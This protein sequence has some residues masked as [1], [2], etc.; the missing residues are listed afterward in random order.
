[1][2]SR[3]R[4]QD[5]YQLQE[6]LGRGGMG[7]VYKARDTLMNR[8]V[9]LKTIL[10]VE[11]RSALDLFYKEWAVQAS[12]VHPNIVE[13]YDIGEFEENGVVKPFFVM[14]LLPGV[15][16]DQLIR[17]GS[18]TLTVERS[19]G[20][21]GQACRGLQAAHDQGLVHR[22][23][24][25]SN[26]F[27]MEDDSVKIIDFGVA[28]LTGTGAKTTLKGTLSYMAP[29]QL[30]MKAPSALSDIF[31]L[32][33]VCYQT[34]TRRLPFHGNSEYEITE[35]IL[36]HSPAPISE[37]NSS[38]NE[39]I[40]S[41]VHK[42]MAKRPW[43]RFPNAK[44][45]A[46]TLQK[47]LHNQPLAFLDPEKIKP[48]IERATKAF[49]EGD[50]DFASEVLFELEA[51]G[52][53]DPQIT[54]MRRQLDQ[55]VRKST[56][57]QLLESARRFFEAAEYGLALRKTQEAL[58]LDED[59]ADALTLQNQIEKERHA[60][61]IDEWFL[62]A[63]Q[64][65][66]N[67]AFGQARQAIE[68]VLKL[69]PSDTHALQLSAEV[70]R[71]ERETSQ[72][73]EEKKKLYEAA[74]KA[75]QKGEITASLSKLESL[76]S[77]E[78]D[79]P[80][81][82][83]GRGSTYQKFYQQVRSEHDS[84]K[85]AY[86]EARTLVRDNNFSAARTLCDQYL[87]KYP[88]HALFQ[89][90]KVDLE[91][92]Q[93][94]RLSAVIAE[95]DQRVDGEPDLDRRLGILQE[96][97]KLYPEEV[98]FERSARIVR[99]KRD[100]VNSIVAKAR[101]FEE[102][103]QLNEALDQWQIL[104]TIHAR[105]PGLE[106]EIERLTK[107][108]DQQA[109]TEAKARWGEQVDRHLESGDYDRAVETC[110]NALAE[111]PNDDSLLELEKL[112]RRSKERSTEAMK[113]LNEGRELC[114][115]GQTEK[116]LE[117][118]RRAQQLDERSSVPRKVLVN[119]LIVAARQLVD[120]N[121]K[122]AGKLVKEVLELEPG[123][124]SAQSLR[125]QIADHEREEFVN[126]CLAQARRLQTEGDIEAAHATVAKG[127]ASYPNEP[128]LK[129]LLAT[130]E[131]VQSSGGTRLSPASR[132]YEELKRLER[133]MAAGPDAN[134]A[135]QL[136]EQVRAIASRYPEEQAIQSLAA[137]LRNRLAAVIGSPAAPGVS[138]ATPSSALDATQLMGGM[139]PPPR[140]PVPAAPAQPERRGAEAGASAAGASA[141]KPAQGKAAAAKAAP[142]KPAGPSFGAVLQQQWASF[143]G[144]I[145]A[146]G[147][148]RQQLLIVGG[149][150]AGVILVAAL[151]FLIWSSLGNEP[152]PPP[153][154]AIR[155]SLQASPSE[156]AISVGEQQCGAGNCE[157][158]LQP[159]TYQAQARLLGY[160]AA[161]VSFEVVAPPAE[162]KPVVLLLEPLAPVLRLTSDLESG[163]VLL[164][165]APVGKL[166]DG[167]FELAN[168][169]MGEHTLEVTTRGS[170][171]SIRF[172]V[173]AGSIPVIG[174]P[175]QASNLKVAAVGSLGSAA[176]L[177]SE[178]ANAEAL[179]DGQA[180]GPVPA[181]GLDLPNLPEGAHEVKLGQGNEQLTFAFNAGG[182]PT[183]AAFLKSDRNVGG[184]RIETG[185]DAVT[186][187]L[188]GQEYRR[189]TQRGRLL[190]Y[191]MPRQYSV[192][193]EKPGF[194]AVGEQVA[195]VVRGE[196]TRLEFKFTP[197]PETASL[198]I[199]NAPPGAEV[200][201]DGG[202]L[203]TIPAGSNTGT[204][205]LAAGTHTVSLRQES[206]TPKEWQR[207]FKAGESV[208]LDG[209][210]LS[211]NGTL[212]ITVEPA[213]ID[214]L[215]TLRRDREAEE[216][217]I[218]A[219]TLTLP[220]GTY[221]VTARADG[222]QEFAA[223]V[224]VGANGTARA[225]IALV[226]DRVVGARSIS[227]LSALAQSGWEQEGKLLTRRGGEFVLSPQGAET[228]IYQFTVFAQ[229]GRRL[230]WVVNFKDDNNHVLYQ[231][232]RDE[233]SRTEVV[234][235][236]KAKPVRVR[237]DVKLDEF[238]SIRVEISADT[239]LHRLFRGQQWTVLDTWRVPGA[240]FSQGKFGFHIPA[241][242]KIGLSSFT[243][244]PL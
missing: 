149:A 200:L 87:A 142:S 199:R 189:K 55:A 203:G 224:R 24:K 14:P 216:R 238:L 139:A 77:L 239:I 43:H 177:Y 132:D 136:T 22:D 227:L 231:L 242:D 69:R 108:R 67:Q 164:D 58:E 176:R 41:V 9:A 117:L 146:P 119:Y 217:P 178:S 23:L 153:V 206:Y 101:F 156:A 16:L 147:K 196:E 220:E 152:A 223:T 53:L 40:S 118:L 233:L 2:A 38:V 116:G 226:K 20:I 228:G 244:T 195:E 186:V 63:R 47:A 11:N 21:I 122:G 8:Q 163:D 113:V 197:L 150:V 183:L 202:R 187:Y 133:V 35:A 65:M 232:E 112:A 170:K 209:A 222:Y 211:L 74:M 151:G 169:P 204:F 96:A 155:V 229:N 188:N 160:Q 86:E 71:L 99:E 148:Q 31:S 201:V 114:D 30:E 210:M 219:K 225:A 198:T 75:W 237:Q 88:Y 190:I 154:A 172:E 145:A 57:R 89:A 218:T 144:T 84:I 181:E 80:D 48:R 91:E 66:E 208:E 234:N 109:R 191:L 131:R 128:R 82:D 194:E 19:I 207:P 81:T 193:V 52:H 185:E 44:E 168:L 125:N 6:V 50:Y 135:A 78:R 230:E 175:I 93:R 105:Y 102:K 60:K 68:S 115:K 95:T 79:R 140:T 72:S 51:E 107:R 103:G 54:L 213:G 62:L 173:R 18:P 85:N 92:L 42:A 28:H 184:L 215:L 36:K 34:L 10:D 56:I 100:L 241:R 129:Q 123:H 157:V 138:S 29:E 59:D 45:F 120:S 240:N 121:W 165:G 174:Q 166:D 137:K 76:V 27:V 236:Q 25:P 73:R 205:T 33:V 49:G 37:I 127:L 90:L 171:A 161:V 7:V 94:Q 110:H 32:A 39:A 162:Q 1:M 64:H 180:A 15:T 141:A 4:L 124:S 126:A 17:E 97:L 235:G 46:E 192:R 182:V 221:T 212:Q 214:P 243:F 143:A 134:S 5:R 158:D 13:I 70:E 83:S 106:L 167:Q 12:I 61:Q 179:L 98:H 111:F 130:I 104:R 159:G 26:L 3:T